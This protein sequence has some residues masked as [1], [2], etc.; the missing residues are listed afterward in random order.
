MPEELQDGVIRVLDAGRRHRAMTHVV[1]DRWLVAYAAAIGDTRPELFDLEHPGGI[2][3]HPVFPACLEWPLVSDGAPG[4][5]LTAATLNRGLHVVQTSTIHRPVA[6]GAAV[7]TSSRLVVAEQRSSAVHLATEFATSDQDGRCASVTRT[8]MLYPGVVL[9][10]GDLSLAA[11]IRP[12]EPSSRDLDP[13]GGFATSAVNAVIYTECA[14]IWNPIHT[15][16]RVAK[17]AGLSAPVLHG[18]ETLARAISTIMAAFALT[19]SEVS[20]YTCRFTA[21]VV[22]GDHLIVRASRPRDRR[23]RFEVC[24]GQGVLVIADGLV[25]AT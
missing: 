6:P 13:V 9:E 21:P 19:A 7:T 24:N 15:D 22:A 5:E 4:V 1:D 16:P 17:S 14:R 18:T 2:V 8:H 10:G 25:C 20:S 3:A 23:I 11:R 12:E